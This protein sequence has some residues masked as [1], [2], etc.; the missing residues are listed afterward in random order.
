MSANE[1]LE[2]AFVLMELLQIDRVVQYVTLPW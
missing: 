2:K 1:A